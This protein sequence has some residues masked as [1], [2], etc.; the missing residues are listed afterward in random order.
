MKDY[1]IN[2]GKH[3][4]GS[5]GIDDQISIVFEMETIEIDIDTAIPLGLIVNELLTNSL[6]YAFPNGRKGE[7]KIALNQVD[8][9]SC[10]LLVSDN[11]IGL[12][13]NESKNNE[14]FGMQLIKLLIKQLDGDMNI[15]TKNGTIVTLDF[16]KDRN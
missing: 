2:L 15:K 3:I 7:I 9:S 10:L 12:P 8:H 11:G 13:K 6:K 5:F 14:G 16:K 1:F 4:L